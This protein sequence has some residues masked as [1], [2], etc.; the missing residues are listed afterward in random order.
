MLNYSM[1]LG[2]GGQGLGLG[3]REIQW[4]P[5]HRSYTWKGPTVAINC[6]AGVLL[7]HLTI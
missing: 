7:K 3:L 1:R 5:L 6:M 2:E 4:P